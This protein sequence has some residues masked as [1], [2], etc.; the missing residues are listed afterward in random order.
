M[1]ESN[2]ELAAPARKNARILVV[3][4][5]EAL[6]G[7]VVLA[8]RQIFSDVSEEF[9]GKSRVR[10]GYLDGDLGWCSP[11]DLRPLP[12]P[13]DRLHFAPDGTGYLYYGLGPVLARLPFLP[14]VDM[15]TTWISVLSIW[16]WAVVGNVCLDGLELGYKRIEPGLERVSNVIGRPPRHCR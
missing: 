13:R 7:E 9:D 5:D 6:R 15:P 12:A 8:L 4:D 1:S 11:D 3:E 2:S 16:F 14:F 10:V